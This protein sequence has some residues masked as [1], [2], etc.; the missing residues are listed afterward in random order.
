MAPWRRCGRVRLTRVSV[1]VLFVSVILSSYDVSVDVV[2]AR[3]I[4]F[5]SII[6]SIIAAAL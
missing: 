1:R 6:G 3:R 5:Y 2:V 4:S